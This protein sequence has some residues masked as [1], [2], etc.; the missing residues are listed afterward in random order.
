MP[1]EPERAKDLLDEARRNFA[2]AGIA[3]AALDARLLLQHG[4]GLRHEDIV[5]GPERLIAADVAEVFRRMVARRGIGE[6]VARI[7]GMREFYGRNFAV[8]PAVLDPRPDTECLIDAALE[9]LAPAAR[10][11]DLG[12]GSGAIIVTLLAE[13]PMAAGVASDISVEALAVAKANGECLGVADRLEFV[14]G[15]WFGAV[16]GHFDLIVSNPPYIPSAGIDGLSPEVRAFDPPGALDGGDDG[17]AAYRHIARGAEAHLSPGGRVLL[18]IG[19]GQENA[20][21]DLF[22][23]HRFEL[24]ASRKDLGGHVRCLVFTKAQSAACGHGAKYPLENRRR[25]AK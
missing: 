3:T 8:T 14:H 12:T 6:P 25:S 15:S 13:R 18:E 5:A 24:G 9:V 16:T 11:V 23:A 7:L 17:L 4:A 22:A 10:I 19:A 20:V 1:M 21:A 2:R